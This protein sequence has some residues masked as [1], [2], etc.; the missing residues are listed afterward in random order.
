MNGVVTS[1][2]LEMVQQVIPRGGKSVIRVAHVGG[3]GSYDVA[4]VQSL[5][6][7]LRL[8]MDSGRA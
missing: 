8:V 3:T 2:S 4:A 1:H 5:A 7:I 6:R